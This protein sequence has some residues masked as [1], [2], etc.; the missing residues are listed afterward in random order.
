M[1]AGMQFL[2]STRLSTIARQLDDPRLTPD[3]I[4]SQRV[5]DYES[6]DGEILTRDQARILVADIIADDS[7]GVTYSTGKLWTE[8]FTIPNLKIGVH[9]QQEAI[10]QLIS[11]GAIG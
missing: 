7:K 1:P 10:N 5:I 4:H 9:F 11:L 8:T 6:Y 3:L 2:N